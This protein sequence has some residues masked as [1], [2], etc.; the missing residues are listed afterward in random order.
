MPEAHASSHIESVLTS[1]ITINELGVVIINYNLKLSNS[2]QTEESLNNDI[3]I[4]LPLEFK[5]KIDGHRINSSATNPELTISSNAKNT[6]LSV[7]TNS[8]F[9]I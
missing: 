9:K 6:I 4:H 3:V 2:G 7:K 8:E 1:E 5:N